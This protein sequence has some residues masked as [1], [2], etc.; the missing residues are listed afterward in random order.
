MKKVLSVL[1]IVAAALLMNGCAAKEEKAA[2]SDIKGKTITIATGDFFEACDKWTPGDKVSFAFTS[3]APVMFNVHYHQKHAK[4]YA[5]DQTLVDTFDGSFIVQSDDIH[6]CMWK[7]DNP[8]FVTL[9][10][11]MTVEGGKE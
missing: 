5:I 8:K 10:Y 7:N 9:T 4:M 3:S 11:D 1:V 6:C 2:H